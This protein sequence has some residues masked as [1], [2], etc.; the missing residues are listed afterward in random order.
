MQHIVDV[1]PSQRDITIEIHL[2]VAEQRRLVEA[3]AKE[4]CFRM[5]LSRGEFVTSSFADWTAYTLRDGRVAIWRKQSEADRLLAGDGDQKALWHA[6]M[7]RKIDDTV[8]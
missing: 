8:E 6:I 3:E 5:W 2:T 7:E 1:D 4:P